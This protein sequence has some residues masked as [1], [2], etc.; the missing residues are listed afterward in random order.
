MPAPRLARRQ[1]RRSNVPGW[2]WRRRP[3]IAAG[4]QTQDSYDNRSQDEEY[5]AIEKCLGFAGVYL[6]R[7]SQAIEVVSV[8]HMRILRFCR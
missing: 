2:Q 1:R 8:D 7:I 3:T 4:T 5:A 6:Q